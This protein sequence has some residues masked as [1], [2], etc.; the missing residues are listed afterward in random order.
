VTLNRRPQIPFDFSKG[1][2]FVVLQ[3]LRLTQKDWCTID[4]L[5]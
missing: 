1:I 3:L 4:K 5:S 2:F